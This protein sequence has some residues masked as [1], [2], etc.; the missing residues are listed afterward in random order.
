MKAPN[1]SIPGQHHEDG[2]SPFVP[3]I[4]FSQD[5]AH[6]QL[7]VEALNRLLVWF[8]QHAIPE[9]VSN[10]RTNMMAPLNNAF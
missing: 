4:Q 8:S 9:N 5:F 1:P 3:T 10:I 7:N 2:T 6:N